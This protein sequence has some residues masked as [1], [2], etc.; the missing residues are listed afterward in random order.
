M[1]SGGLK[2]ELLR[3]SVIFFIDAKEN[4]CTFGAI[5]RERDYGFFHC[6]VWLIIDMPR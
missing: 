3:F 2:L 6:Q 1:G 4:H 5:G